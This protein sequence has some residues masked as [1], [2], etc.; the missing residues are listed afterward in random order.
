PQLLQAVKQTISAALDHQDYP[1]EELINNLDIQRDLSRNP[2]FETMFSFR[3]VYDKTGQIGGVQE[4]TSFYKHKTAMFSIRFTAW[5]EGPQI[6]C[7][8]E[9][10]TKLFAKETME[11]MARY[12]AQIM[13]QVVAE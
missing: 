6:G 5:E 1:F 3:D 8:I 4:I 9:Y 2:L 7:E 11:R 10:S 13:Q 12:F